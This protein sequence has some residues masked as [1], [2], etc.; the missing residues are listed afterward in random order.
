MQEIRS[1]VILRPAMPED[2]PHV[3]G[4][5][6][7]FR[8]KAITM[9]A[10]DQVLGVG[11][12]AFRPEGIIEAFVQ[13]VPEAKRYPVAFHRAGLMAMMMIRESGLHEVMATADSDDAAAQRWLKRLGF[14][15]VD[16]RPRDGKLP[17]VWKRGPDLLGDR[18][19]HTRQ[20]TCDH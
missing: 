9:L 5:S 12:I 7:P 11:G 13:Q 14:M 19:H 1:P 3:I 8:I 4:E 10:G 16:A 18:K 20:R 2:L 15:P 17:F 6:L